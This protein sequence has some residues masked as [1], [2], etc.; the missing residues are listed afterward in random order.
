M[1]FKIR[2]IKT[3]YK[4][5]T[6]TAVA[7]LVLA[8][9]SGYAFDF[10]GADISDGDVPSVYF[11][12]GLYGVRPIVNSVAIDSPAD[13]I[14]LRRGNIILSIN[15]LDIKKSTELIQFSANALSLLV[16]NGFEAKVVTIDRLAPEPPKLKATAVAKK[17]TGKVRTGFDFP[18]SSP[19]PPPPVLISR[20]SETER[21]DL[22]VTDAPTHQTSLEVVARIKQLR[23]NVPAVQS[24]REK[25]DR[26]PK[27][28]PQ[29]TVLPMEKNVSNSTSLPSPV[30]AS[31]PVNPLSQ[32]TPPAKADIFSIQIKPAYDNVMFENGKGNVSFKHSIH[33]KSLN[34]EQCLQCHR[35]ANP[36]LESIQSRLN[37]DRTAHSLCRGCHQKME[38]GPTTECYQCHNSTNRN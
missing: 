11:K 27:S 3:F 16:L 21:R 5:F 28:E 20:A 38:K 8:A 1:Y 25:P 6:F 37:N 22:I 19:N 4:L 29:K 2:Y 35:M 31:A 23:E 17:T 18:V 13:K 24:N 26:I 10:Y 34:K 36:T 32:Q 7:G 9:T 30:I 14:G 12:V 33:L 15:G